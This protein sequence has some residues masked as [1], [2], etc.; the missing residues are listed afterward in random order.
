[1]DPDRPDSLY[2]VWILLAGIVC[3]LPLA[4][5][6]AAAAEVAAILRRS[7]RRTGSW[8]A[9]LEEVLGTW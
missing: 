2:R 3:S 6:I 9:A 7:R 4:L 1:V 8:V 5:L